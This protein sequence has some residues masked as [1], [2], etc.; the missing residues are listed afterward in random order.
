MANLTSRDPQHER[1]RGHPFGTAAGEDR[2]RLRG[3]VPRV[4]Q[5]DQRVTPRRWLLL[6]NPD[7]AELL[8]E[9]VGDSWV[10]DLVAVDT[11]VALADDSGFLDTFRLRKA[12][13]GRFAD[14]S[15]RRASRS[16]RTRSST[17]KSSG[18]TNTSG[19]SERAPGRGLYNRLRA[20]PA[21]DVPPGRSCSRAR[22][23]RPTGSRSSSS[24]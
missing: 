13:P 24:S 22:R 5:Q 3:D 1:R 6:G 16:T 17:R 2:R 14:W 15:P 21:L 11:V 19:N 8:T 7:L 20:N 12:R 23:P 18:S 10:T 4:Q 9:G